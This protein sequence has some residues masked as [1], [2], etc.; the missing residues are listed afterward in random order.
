MVKIA[1]LDDSFSEIFALEAS[2]VEGQSLPQKDKWRRKGEKNEKNTKSL[3][4]RR[5]SLAL[6]KI[7]EGSSRIFEDLHE[8]L[9]EDLDQDL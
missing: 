8:D 1:G 2:P 7:F 9:C 6:V 3:K 4:I 5:R